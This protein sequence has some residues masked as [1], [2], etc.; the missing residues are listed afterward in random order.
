MR[1]REQLTIHF[2]KYHAEGM[3]IKEMAKKIF[4]EDKSISL[5]VS[6]MVEYLREIKRENKDIAVIDNGD[7][8]AVERGSYVFTVKGDTKVYS[9]SFID[10]LFTHYSRKGYNFTRIKTQLKFDLSSKAFGQITRMF[11]LS[12]DC[13]ILS[14]YTLE[15]TDKKELEGIIESKIQTILNSG[16][17]TSQRYNDAVTRKHR[18][19]IEGDLLEQTWRQDVIGELIEELPECENIKLKKADYKESSIYEMAAVCGDLHAGAEAKD[20]KITEDWSM[21]ILI[22]KLENMAHSINESRAEH[23]DLVILADLVESVS[24]LNHLN[25]WKGLGKGLYGAN[26]IIQTYEILV[27]HL[28]NNITNLRRICGCGGNHDRLQSSNHNNDTGA[29][30]LIFYMLEMR[31]QETEIEIVYDPVVISIQLNNFGVIGVHGDK[32]LHKR[33]I[34][35]LI[36]KFSVDRNQYQFVMSAHLHSFFCQRNDDQDIGRRVTVPSIVTGNTYSDLDVGRSSK[37]GFIK[38]YSNS[39]KQPEMVIVNI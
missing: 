36:T 8:W 31:L 32:G 25:T 30:D 3:K 28:I 20:M 15:N 14:P 7:T 24:G 22:E 6:S 2:K 21:E 16:E 13:D 18:R 11:N 27:K 35:Y 23:V 39:F 1:Y 26:I 29:T 10:D 37:S 19:V 33:S 38:L 4:E 5:K 17:M 34:E 9:V 12:K